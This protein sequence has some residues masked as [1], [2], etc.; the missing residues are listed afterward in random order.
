[1][2]ETL[3]QTAQRLWDEGR[4][5]MKDFLYLP[6]LLSSYNC[7]NT[8]PHWVSPIAAI[9]A[10]KNLG[11]N[12]WVE[13]PVYYKRDLRGMEDHYFPTVTLSRDNLDEAYAAI[14]VLDGSIPVWREAK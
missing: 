7:V 1:M 5:N 13:L 14:T 4:L 12:D 6:S 2:T 8:P 3:K 11:H 9:K 10:I